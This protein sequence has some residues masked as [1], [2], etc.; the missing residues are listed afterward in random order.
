MVVFCL[1]A[2]AAAGIPALDVAVELAKVG[3]GRLVTMD[4]GFVCRPPERTTEDGA[5]VRLRDTVITGAA[6]D[7]VEIVGASVGN[8]TVAVCVGFASCPQT[9]G[10]PPERTTACALE[11]WRGADPTLLG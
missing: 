4:T 7:M 9:L 6:V 8:V 2:V 3:R 1:V 5:C 11:D 10:R